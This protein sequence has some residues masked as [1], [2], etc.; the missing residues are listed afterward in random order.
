MQ[1]QQSTQFNKITLKIRTDFK[2]FYLYIQHLCNVIISFVF[3]IIFLYK[4][5]PK[6]VNIKIWGANTLHKKTENGFFVQCRQERLIWHYKLIKIIAM[7]FYIRI[8]RIF[9]KAGMRL[10]MYECL[11]KYI[12]EKLLSVHITLS[13]TVGDCM[14]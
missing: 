6:L 12:L 4:S 9:M 11:H 8:Y 3:I 1:G 7:G 14:T 5:S 13:I 10:R 2:V